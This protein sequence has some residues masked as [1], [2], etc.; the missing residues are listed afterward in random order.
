MTTVVCFT[1]KANVL[2][3]PILR[4]ELEGKVMSLGWTTTDKPEQFM[5]ASDRILV[6]TRD[7][8]KKAKHARSMG[9]AIMTPDEFAGHL[10]MNGV[11]ELTTAAGGSINLA[12]LHRAE[13]DAE[14]RDAEKRRDE[15]RAEARRFK[16]KFEKELSAMEELEGFG[17]WS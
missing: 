6:A 2:G 3:H 16:E 1:G 15:S 5:G 10:H 9:W 14:K 7:D 17:E 11:G 8:T 4:A 12:G 13:R